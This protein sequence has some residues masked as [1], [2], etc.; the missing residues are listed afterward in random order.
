MLHKN[1]IVCGAANDRIYLPALDIL[2]PARAKIKS[3]ARSLF[4][5]IKLNISSGCNG[6]G[7][8]AYIGIYRRRVFIVSIN[9][10]RIFR[11]NVTNWTTDALRSALKFD[12]SSLGGRSVE[13]LW[14]S[15]ALGRWRYGWFRKI[16]WTGR[17]L[18]RPRKIKIENKNPFRVNG[19]LNRRP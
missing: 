12:C 13:W 8:G 11:Y 19:A 7:I 9:I 10:R 14:F 15:S 5:L 2:S 16:D 4:I 17:S 3:L 6:M 18:R 1:G